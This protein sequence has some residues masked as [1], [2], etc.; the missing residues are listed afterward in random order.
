MIASA[1]LSGAILAP[2]FAFSGVVILRLRKS[3][4][5]FLWLTAFLG[6]TTSWLFLLGVRFYLPHYLPLPNWQPAAFFPIS[7]ALLADGFSWAVGFALVTVGGAVILTEA[8]TQEGEPVFGWGSS[9]LLVG[10]GLV[11][12]FAGN[13]LSLLLAW[14][15]IDIVE[16]ALWLSRPPHPTLRERVVLSFAS[17]AFGVMLSLWG[18]GN[19]WAYVFSILLRWGIFPFHL[20]YLESS[21]LRR[22]LGTIIRLVPPLTTIP[23]LARLADMAYF[24]AEGWIAVFVGLLGLFAA[25]LWVGTAHVLESRPFWII[26]TAAFAFYAAVLHYPETVIAWGM[27]LALCGSFLFLFSTRYRMWLGGFA[28]QTLLLL[29]LPFTPFWD[30]IRIYQ[31]SF[32]IP[33]L[34]FLLSHLLL[35]VGYL[36]FILQKPPLPLEGEPWSKALYFVAFLGV[37]SASLIVGYGGWN[38]L[39]QTA[40]SQPYVRSRNWAEYSFG[41]GLM[42]FGGFG[43]LLYRLQ[44]LPRW[45]F[46]SAW[47]QFFS[48][49][50]GYRAFQ[51]G[52]RQMG[53]LFYRIEAVVEGSGGML[54]AIV[55]LLILARFLFVLGG[56]E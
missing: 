27:I 9:L 11:A 13:Q 39:L 52:F 36:R 50:W 53:G 26:G 16:L 55:L 41:L 49:E 42:A 12:I 37:I 3:R 4:L 1:L 8:S 43:V 5:G 51:W 40:L 21:L 23:L 2:L 48:M 56:G 10:L 19:P 7:P 15:S 33:L 47:R 31:F 14:A 35:L 34:T 25:I 6:M 18:M 54:W 20:P 29:G 28:Y 24:A 22:G 46:P 30:L 45:Q 38:D 32:S 44:L 17:R